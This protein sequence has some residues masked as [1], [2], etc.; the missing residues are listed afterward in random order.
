MTKLTPFSSIRRPASKEPTLWDP[1]AN[2]HDDFESLF[3][4]L[5]KGRLSPLATFKDKIQTPSIDVSET[6]DELKIEADMP[7]MDE[8][9]VE[10]VLSD[11]ILTIKGHKNTEQEEKKKDYHLIERSS[12]SVSRSIALPFEADPD[13]IDAHFSKGVLTIKLPK[14]AEVQ[15]K[16]HRIAIKG[17]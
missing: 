6:D 14:P 9:D 16:T 8:N 7:G 11:N 5:S 13:Q 17:K 4:E 12:G 3:D 1:F 2:L 10:V 15:D